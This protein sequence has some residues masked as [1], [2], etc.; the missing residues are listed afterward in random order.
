MR[1][2]LWSVPTPGVLGGPKRLEQRR[3]FIEAHLETWIKDDPSL[4]MEGL[5]WVGRQVTFPDRSRLDLIGLTREGQLVIAELKSAAVGIGT[6][7][8]ALQ[9]A[10][11]VGTLEAASL[12]R[13]LDLDD[14]ARDLLSSAV[15]QGDLDVSILLVGTSRRPELDQAAAFLAS[16]G[17]SIPVRIVT[18]TP[19]VDAS[20]QILL[21]REVEEHEQEPDEIS[22]KQRSSRAAKIEWVQESAREYGVGEVVDE[23]IATAAN[24]GLRVKPWPKSLTI[25]PPNGRG[26]TLVYVAPKSGKI[27]FGY[28][29]TNFS[30]IYDAD[31]QEV[32]EMLGDNWAELDPHTARQ[33]LAGFVRLMNSLLP[34]SDGPAPVSAAHGPAESDA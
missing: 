29:E 22:P 26:R 3:E 16:R 30:D 7:A 19:F 23:F 21:A 33:R 5:T 11:W 32:H 2:A 31:P 10:L 27:G 6:L 9:Y 17:L 1:V 24:L 15:A 14:A 28:S 13:R 25:V 4:V 34:D 18:F 20:G 8:Q 12:L